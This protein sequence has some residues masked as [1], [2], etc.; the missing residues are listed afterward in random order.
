M[1]SVVERTN[2]GQQLED[3]IAFIFIY[4]YLNRGIIQLEEEPPLFEMQ[5]SRFL[6]FQLSVSCLVPCTLKENRRK[7]DSVLAFPARS[8]MLRPVHVI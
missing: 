7:F 1:P 3:A 6:A 2:E 5:F 8:V 4:F